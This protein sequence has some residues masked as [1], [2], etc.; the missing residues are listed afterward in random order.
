[1]L[2]IFTVCFFGHRH[3]DISSYQ[4]LESALEELIRNLINEKQ[5]VDFLVG[6]DGDFDHMVSATI[7]RVKRNYFDANSSHI[8]V[9]PY[10]RAE[11]KNNIKAFE[12]YY[13]EIEICEQSSKAFYKS[14]IQ[15]RNRCMI[16]RSDLCVFYVISSN[17]GSFVS[18]QYAKAQHKNIL[19]LAQKQPAG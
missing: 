1:M 7:R 6:R 11:F 14:A 16:D 2:D 12:D 18:F 9:L 19:N 8:C 3:I 5:Y 10:V 17:G 13:D 15:I 4:Y